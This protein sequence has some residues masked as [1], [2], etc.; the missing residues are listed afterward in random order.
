MSIV[1]KRRIKEILYIFPLALIVGLTPLIVRYKKITLGRVV[2][3]YWMKDVNTDF[4]SYYKMWTFLGFVL[5]AL[6]VFYIYLKNENKLK[7]TFYYI[8]VAVYI[9][10]VVISTIFSECKYTS[11][12]GFPDRYEGMPVLLGYM[13]VLV[14]AVN[15]VK[16][17]RQIKFLLTVLL[18][19]A[20]IIGIIGLYQFFGM[21]F[22]QSY[23]AQKL[24]LPA[25]GY[26]E[27]LSK[28]N[29]RFDKK[30]LVYATL[31]NPNYVGS[32]FVILFI[33]TFVMYIFAGNRENR[34]LYGAINLLMFA[35]WLGSLSRAGILGGIFSLLLLGFL[36]R[37]EFKKRWQSLIIIFICFAVIFTVMDLYTEGE[38]SGEFISLGKETKVAVEGKPARIEDISIKNNSLIFAAEDKTLVIAFDK[39]GN[40][41]FNNEKGGNL[42]YSLITEDGYEFIK[43]IDNDYENFKLKPLHN[44][45]N[46]TK[47]LE[48]Y[49]NNLRVNF[50]IAPDLNDY[51]IVGMRGNIYPIQEVEHL[52]FSG[53]E[54]FASG[55]GYIWSRSI[56]L[57]KKTM[58]KG[59]GPDTYA[60]YFPQHDVGGKLKTFGSAAKIVDKPHNMYLQMALNTGLLSLLAI[61]VLFAVYF[62]R[63]LKIYLSN[64]YENW[65]ARAGVAI[66]T[67]FAGYAVAGFFNDSVISVAPVFWTMLGTGIAVELKLKNCS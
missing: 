6:I 12:F 53:K 40:L 2:A 4:F 18:I 8:P 20:V 7:N 31:Y 34:I 13:L 10:M 21:D 35:G 43:F 26:E 39:S 58:L 49:Y 54:R 42:A 64:N 65:F 63:N 3:S 1:E 15:F 25:S 47:F 27:I 33:I 22:F 19:S 30:D 56:P 62:I 52:F 5:F 66:F 50:V 44:E 46:E 17:K 48:L 55:R 45:I 11:L 28:L 24:I 37:N 32:Y 57:L 67:A 61:L 36:L 60:I 38:L 16:S 23:F 14:L 59:F 9:L 29:Y 51:W 41:L